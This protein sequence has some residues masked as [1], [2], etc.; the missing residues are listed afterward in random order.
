[1]TTNLQEE[2]DLG[3][4]RIL[5]INDV[6]AFQAVQGIGG[7][8]EISSLI[9]KYRTDHSL[10]VI[11]GDFLGG[12]PLAE[13]FN[14][15]CVID[16]LNA[17][18]VDMCV[19]GN[20][21]FDFGNEELKK[22]INESNF[23]WL[24]SNIRNK[25]TGEIFGSIKDTLIK[26]F[27]FEYEYKGDKSKYPIKIG[28]FGVCTRDTPILS[29]PGKDVTFEPVLPCAQDKVKELHENVVDTIIGL[30]HI[31][32][33]EDIE[34][35]EKIPGITCLLGGHDHFP[36]ATVTKNGC[37]IMKCGQ[38]AYWLGVIDIKFE[39][40]KLYD[41][42]NQLISQE[43][44]YYT[45]WQ[46]V[47]NR[48]T[49][50]DPKIVE[51]IEKYSKEKESTG[52]K[53]DKSELIAVVSN[54]P[55]TTKTNIVRTGPAAILNYVTDAMWNCHEVDHKIADFA[56]INGG[57]V[58]G[59]S[60]YSVGCKITRGILMEEF[61]FPLTITQLLIK[62]KYLLEAIEQHIA[63][64]PAPLGSFPHFSS[65]LRVTIDLSRP[66]M[67]RVISMTHNGSPIE[68]EKEYVVTTSNFLSIGG[69]GCSAYKHGTP[70][71]H[72][73]PLFGM[74]MKYFKQVGHLDGGAEP[75]LIFQSN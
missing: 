32:L 46:M 59:D 69:D 7:Y 23:A 34:I 42:L 38:N 39:L 36:Y 26:E 35:S 8:A 58:R 53:I 37:L 44:K 19:A 25:D 27:E 49:T 11:N 61:P 16:V 21:E 15:K 51:I 65:T 31:P 52:E 22:R 12:S 14:G 24:G 9:K 60:C 68:L 67:S 20:H 29:W 28:F 50:P 72:L 6:Y 41:S 5:S 62:G 55:L 66:P 57:I 73:A 54:K 70:V 18:G 2:I 71:G 10:L 74:I 45:S 47:I 56:I 64:S 1:M 75:R 33:E 43:I 48:K 4:L 40:H 63:K 3:T 30:T 13:H 17:M